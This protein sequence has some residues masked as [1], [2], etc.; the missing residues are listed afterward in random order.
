MASPIKVVQC[1]VSFFSV[2]ILILITSQ[3]TDSRVWGLSTGIRHMNPTEDKKCIIQHCY[4][5]HYLSIFKGMHSK[6]YIRLIFIYLFI[7]CWTQI[8]LVPITFDSRSTEILLLG[9]ICKK[10][11]TP[12]RSKGFFLLH[13]SIGYREQSA[14]KTRF[15]TDYLANIL[16]IT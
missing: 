6:A 15:D 11:F 9:V 4:T 10:E 5:N 14:Y 3:T 7:L 12:K 2:L 8:P 1:T 16:I 13:F